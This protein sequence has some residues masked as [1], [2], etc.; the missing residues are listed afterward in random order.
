MLN[1]L[2]GAEDSFFASQ[3]ALIGLAIGLILGGLIGWLAGMRK[4]A[5]DANATLQPL[6]DELRQQL[7][8]RE[9]T[10]AQ[11][12]TDLAETQTTLA[13]AQATQRSV[14][15]SASEQRAEDQQSLHEALTARTAVEQRFE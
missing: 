1:P 15:A 8:V 9:A 11:A 10:L 5:A 4:A 13:V 6:T 12:Q 2:I 3:P 14:E 7:A